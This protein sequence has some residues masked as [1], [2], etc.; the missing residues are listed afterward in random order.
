MATSTRRRSSFTPPRG[1]PRSSVYS[2]AARFRRDG[3]RVYDRS[4]PLRP[5]RSELRQYDLDTYGTFRSRPRDRLQ[6]HEVLQQMWLP[7]HQRARRG[8]SEVS[9]ENP[10]LALPDAVHR[11]V[12][13]L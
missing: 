3:G 8:R 9:V 2:R 12:T 4:Q 13:N 6:G 7:L 10:A 5:G 11:R 1:V